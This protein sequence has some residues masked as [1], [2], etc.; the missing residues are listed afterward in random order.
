[1]AETGSGNR[2]EIWRNFLRKHWKIL[3]LFVAVAILLVTDAILVFVWFV[4]DA[5][6]TSLV[7][8]RLDLWTMGYVVTFLIWLILWEILFVGIPTILAAVGGWLWWK[9]LPGDERREYHFF[10]TR[11]R[12]TTGGGGGISFV[13]FIAF[14]IKVYLDGKWNEAFA[15]WTFDYLA[16]SYLSAF[17]WVL[18]ICGIPAGLGV[19]WWIN[20]EMKK[21][22]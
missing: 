6:S 3:A 5:Q 4:G 14:C 21:K 12:A 13:V 16:Y 9:R 7:P 19:L 17:L 8:K 20:H 18:V 2:G 15:T 11:S 1:M 10:S 22:P